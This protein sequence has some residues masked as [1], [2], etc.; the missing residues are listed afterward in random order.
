MPDDPAA[1]RGLDGLT[2]AELRA[3]RRRP[4]RRGHRRVPRVAAELRRARRPADPAIGP[5]VASLAER[6]GFTIRA[7]FPHVV[8]GT[9]R[10]TARTFLDRVRRVLAAMAAGLPPDVTAVAACRA[11]IDRAE[12]ALGPDRVGYGSQLV[13]L[14]VCAADRLRRSS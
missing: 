8:G 6:A 14:F 11:Q 1:G 13:P 4:A 3:S 5:A 9:R 12:A 10:D 2:A 7:Q